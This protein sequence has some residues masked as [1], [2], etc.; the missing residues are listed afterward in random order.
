MDILDE[1]YT[2]EDH[3][4]V[5][6]NATTHTK[7]AEG[8]LSARYMPKSTHEWGVEVN[9]QGANGKPLYGPNGKIVKHK[10]KMHDT[11]FGDGSPQLL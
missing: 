4:L 2:E 7:R 5:F 11:T 10:V 8:A 6:D 3:V 1:H 9:L